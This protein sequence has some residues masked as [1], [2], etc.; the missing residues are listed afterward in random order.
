MSRS[1]IFKK[2]KKNND[3]RRRKEYNVN[4]IKKSKRIYKKLIIHEQ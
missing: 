1:M 2:I 4:N 3:S